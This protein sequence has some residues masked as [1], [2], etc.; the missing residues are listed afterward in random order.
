MG[1]TDVDPPMHGLVADPAR[2]ASSGNGARHLDEVG[3]PDFIAGDDV[4]HL[5]A[6][7]ARLVI[8]HPQAGEVGPASA[9]VTQFR[10]RCDAVPKQMWQSC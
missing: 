6:A 4:I 2:Q 10:R 7:R 1:S 3:I 5:R 9:D 8:G